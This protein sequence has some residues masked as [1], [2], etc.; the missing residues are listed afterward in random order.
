MYS[1]LAKDKLF[2]VESIPPKQGVSMWAAAIQ[3][4]VGGWGL[5]GLPRISPRLNNLQRAYQSCGVVYACIMR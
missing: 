2:F 3:L 4:P 1:G 5:Q